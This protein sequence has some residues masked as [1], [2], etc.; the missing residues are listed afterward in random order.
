VD[1]ACLPGLKKT[2]IDTGKVR[3]VFREFLTEPPSFA[4]A[5]F[6]LSRS[7]SRQVFRSAGHG[8]RQA[9]RDL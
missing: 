6:L 5:G 1:D 4:A 9:G 3:L 2:Y 7:R 8:V